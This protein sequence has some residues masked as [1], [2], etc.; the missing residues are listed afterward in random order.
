VHDGAR[1]FV[2]ASLID[3]AIDAAAAF[4]AA[5]PGV[6]V[7]DTVK[8]VDAA[9]AVLETLDRTTLR[10]VQT[11]Q[12]FQ[13]DRLLAAHDR[14]KAENLDGFTDDAQLLEWAGHPVHVFDGDPANVKLTRAED[15]EEAERRLTG[16][17]GTMSG[18][19]GSAS[20]TAGASSP[21]RTAMSCFTR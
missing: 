18:W 19:A 6:A 21:I 8:R 2:G 1:P 13:F 16:S 7:T 12:A 20:P 17:G 4:G 11:P 3:G 5:T 10:A 15:F 14:A 9:G